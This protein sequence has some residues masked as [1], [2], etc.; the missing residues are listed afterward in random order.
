MTPYVTYLIIGLTV[1]TSYQAFSDGSMKWKMMFNAY[2]IKHRKEWYRLFSSGLI[3]A[4]WMHLG[5]NMLAL[6]FFGPRVEYT[7]KNIFGDVKGV[8]NYTLLYIASIAVS[9]FYNVVK[10]QDNHN[11]NSLGASGAVS[12]IVFSSIAIDPMNRIGFLFL[13]KELYIPGVVFGF[14]YL[15]YSQ[16]MAKKQID[17]I[18]HDAHFWGA[19]FGF[20]I[21]FV[22]EPKLLEDF[23]NK[24]MYSIG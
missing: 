14:L 4:D 21:T 23:F 18:G 5:F 15:G 9:S 10:H 17:N 22:F 11:Y 2:Q 12:A 6:Y 7:F 8:I 24:I 3:H 13:P 19:V 20:V 16:Y 1:Y